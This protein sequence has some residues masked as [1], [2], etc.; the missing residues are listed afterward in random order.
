[1]ALLEVEIN[2][3]KERIDIV[4]MD[5]NGTDMFLGHNPEVDWNKGTI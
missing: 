1:M 3:H 4:A 2:R 5:L